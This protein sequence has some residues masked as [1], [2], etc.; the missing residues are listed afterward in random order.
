MKSVARPAPESSVISALQLQGAYF[1]DPMRHAADAGFKA[2]HFLS[3]LARTITPTQMAIRSYVDL[4]TGSGV[5]ARLVAQ[6]LRDSGFDLQKTTGYDVSPHVRDLARADGVEFVYGDF[7]ATDQ[8]VDLVTLFDV[9]EH[10]TDPITFL[11]QVSQHCRLVGLHLPL[12]D[13]INVAF[14]D[15]FHGKVRDPGHVIFLNSVEALNLLAFAGLRVLDYQYTLGFTA[16]SGHSSI[17]ARL[18]RPLRAFVAKLSPWLLAKTLGG[19]SL[20]IVALTP[21]GVR[22]LVAEGEKP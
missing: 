13:S 14:R 1:E 2:E 12:D 21:A 10:V 20:M 18:L 16:P 3:L 6:G 7:T 22:S 4:G 5:A 9:V 15:L 8:F 17:S 11:K 19:A